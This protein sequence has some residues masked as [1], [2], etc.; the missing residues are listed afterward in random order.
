MEE[1][2]LTAE[3]QE[4]LDAHKK[5]L[6]EKIRRFHSKND[7]R[8]FF[9]YEH[10]WEVSLDL[11]AAMYLREIANEED[12]NPDENAHQNVLHNYQKTIYGILWPKFKAL[13][14]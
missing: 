8:P 12:E 5:M 2:T 11:D 14:S 13:N 7:L 4:T 3:E 10:I 6:D 1:E 9:F